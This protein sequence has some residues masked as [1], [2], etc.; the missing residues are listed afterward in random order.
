MDQN[1]KSILVLD[2]LLD[3]SEFFTVQTRPNGP[4]HNI[5]G[6]F[7]FYPGFLPEIKIAKMWIKNLK[8][9]VE[10]LFHCSENLVVKIRPK[11][12]PVT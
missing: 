5:G 1:L 3:Q 11:R 2:F 8:L 12:P 6:I 4:P 10:F 9:L 7:N